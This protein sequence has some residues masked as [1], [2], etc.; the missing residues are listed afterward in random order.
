M[1]AYVSIVIKVRNVKQVRFQ[2]LLK[3]SQ[4]VAVPD[5]RGETV[6]HSGSRRGE[7]ARAEASCGCSRTME[8]TL[9]QLNAAGG[10]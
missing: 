1:H 5:G 3:N 8:I 2:T 10:A 9:E 6:P 4:R 7:A